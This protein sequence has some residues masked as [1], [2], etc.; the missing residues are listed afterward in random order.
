VLSRNYASERTLGE[1]FF[2]WHFQIGFSK[3]IRNISKGFPTCSAFQRISKR[4]QR[5][6]KGF[7]S[8]SKGLP[9]G[10]KAFPKGFQRVSK[11]F[12]R[13]SKCFKRVSKGFQSVSK[14][15][16]KGFRA[17]SNPLEN[18]DKT[19]F[20]MG[21]HKCIISRDSINTVPWVTQDRLAAIVII[22]MSLLEPLLKPDPN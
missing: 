5:V 6:S 17:T 2:P 16:P 22:Y 1:Y 8:I 3:S 14:G 13:V 10:F 15:F 4:F 11:C 12:K 9:K 21:G 7:Q 18:V 19:R 20:R